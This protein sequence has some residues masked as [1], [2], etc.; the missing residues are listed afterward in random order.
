MSKAPTLKGEEPPLPSNNPDAENLIEFYHSEF[1]ICP[2]SE[3]SDEE[4]H[5]LLND[6]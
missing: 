6:F 3:F 4:Q 5:F 1:L 2:R